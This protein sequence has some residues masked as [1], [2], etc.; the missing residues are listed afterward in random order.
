MATRAARRCPESRVGK[1]SHL[2]RNR[3]EQGVLV[4]DR[5]AL[6]GCRSRGFLN[7]CATPAGSKQLHAT[8][9]CPCASAIFCSTI[10]AK[11]NL[12]VYQDRT[13]GV[14]EW[15]AR[16]CSAQTGMWRESV[17]VSVT[18]RLIHGTAHAL[19]NSKL[20]VIHRIRSVAALPRRRP[21]RGIYPCR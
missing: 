5:I 16:F 1:R 13:P 11:P 15:I 12:H 14:A 18:P 2:A 4:G 20:V 17:H 6:A 10:V 3:I 9:G 7:G 8:E 19:P 21:G